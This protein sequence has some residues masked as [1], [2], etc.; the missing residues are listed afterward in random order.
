MFD[1]TGKVLRQV[2]RDRVVVTLKS[3]EAFDGVLMAADG[4]AWEL[5][6][7]KALGVGERGADVPV[8]GSMILPAD[9]IAY[10]QRP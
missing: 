1:S 7:A 8:D 6:N 2:M 9:N 3:G 10:C 4:R 5:V